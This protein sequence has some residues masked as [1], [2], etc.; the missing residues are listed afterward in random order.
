MALR[1]VLPGTRGTGDGASPP[2]AYALRQ[3]AV[4]AAAGRRGPAFAGTAFIEAYPD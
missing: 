4:S 3:A 2:C 1:F